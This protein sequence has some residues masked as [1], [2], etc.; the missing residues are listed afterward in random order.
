M[1]APKLSPE[2]KKD[3]K[4]QFNVDTVT[5]RRLT[6]LS[7]ALE[8]PNLSEFLRSLVDQA[9][10][11]RKSRIKKRIDQIDEDRESKLRKLAQLEAELDKEEPYLPA[12]DGTV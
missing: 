1:P 10:A 6:A 12:A 7:E 8:Y 3:Q 2:V 11:E 9:L 4:L 5:L